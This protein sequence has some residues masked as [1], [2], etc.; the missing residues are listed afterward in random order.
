LRTAAAAASPELIKLLVDAGADPTIPGRLTLTPLDRLRDTP[1]RGGRR[2]R[3]WRRC[4]RH[5][6]RK[7]KAEH[8]GPRAAK[9]RAD[10]SRVIRGD[11]PAARGAA[12]RSRSGC[13]GGEGFRG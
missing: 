10:E 11:C 3:T 2:W 4:W 9:R 7:R 13:T 12:E 6:R 8:A 1:L 5:A